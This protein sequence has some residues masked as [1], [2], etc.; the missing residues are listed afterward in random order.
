MRP[1][2][3]IKALLVESDA[4]EA[5]RIQEMLGSGVGIAVHWAG[6]L[7]K[8][9][10]RM[11]HSRYDVVLLSL[12]LPDGAGLAGFARLREKAPALPVVVLNALEDDALALRVVRAGAEDY[13]VTGTLEAKSLARAVRYSVERASRRQARNRRSAVRD[14]RA[15]VLGFLGAKGGVGTT[16]VA[17]N[18]GAALAAAGHKTIVAELRGRFGTLAELASRAVPHGNLASLLALE[19]D[20]INPFEVNARLTRYSSELAFLYGPRRAAEQCDLAPEHAAAITGALARAARFTVL[21]LPPEPSAANREAIRQC[22]FLGLVVDREKASVA[23]ARLMLGTVRSWGA[24]GVTGL[25]VTQRSPLACPYDLD[26]L[27]Q[28]T[29]SEIIELIPPA[30]DSCATASQAGAPAI[31]LYVDTL[32][33]ASYAALAAKLSAEP[34]LIRKTA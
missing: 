13:L 22:D 5:A 30:A 33:A 11:A 17:L 19:P 6:T 24:G 28:E 7:A 21:D 31:E 14:P 26:Q 25:I 1:K 32:L 8:A 18:V 27:V 12:S 20:A 2:G 9:L 15:R 29:G 3:T 23:S 34:I 10:D 16:T 4:G